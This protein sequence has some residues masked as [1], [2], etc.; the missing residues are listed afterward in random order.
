MTAPA[1]S[2]A[3]R[4][5]GNFLPPVPVQ[6]RWRDALRIWWREVDRVLLGLILGLLMAF[7][8]I[9]VAAA[10]PGQRG[11][12]FHRA[13]NAHPTLFLHSPPRLAIRR[14]PCD[15]R[16]V[17]A[18][19]R[20]GAAAVG[21][22]RGGDAGRAV[23]GAHTRPRPRD[24]RGEALARSRDAL[25]AVGVPQ[26][27]LRHAMAWIL[28]WRMR[29]PTIPTVALTGHS[30]WHHRAAADDAAEPGRCDPVRG[31]LVRADAARG[32][33]YEGAGDARSA[34]GV[35]LLTAAYVFYDNARHR[36]DAFLGGGTAFDQV[37]LAQPHASA[38]GAGS[39]RATAS[40]SAR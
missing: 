16:R 17:H 11:P 12:A 24:E 18:E 3:P 23:P 36:I 7:G 13:G 27:H 31:L 5:A 28:S 21:G 6:R 35:A 34:A 32:R 15:D 14:H 10:S 9:A 29:D 1:Y 39:A 20:A 2:S 8:S 4:G 33:A 26:A 22:D 19:P 38:P 40:A 37:D 25:P 30:A